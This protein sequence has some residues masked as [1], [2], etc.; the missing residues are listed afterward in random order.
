MDSVSIRPMSEGDLGAAEHAAAVTF[1][2]GDRL[3]RMADEPEPQPPT[4]DQS[5]RWVEQIGY[6]L[7]VDPQGC[8]V[9]ERDGE[10]VGFAVSQNRGPLWY[11][12]TYGVLPSEQGKG[13]GQRL[14]DAVLAHADGRPG[15]FSSTVHPAATRRYR[16]TSDPES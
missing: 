13:V 2:E 8:W 12:A 10:I 14:M 7:S 16:L 6:L 4:P 11:L 1:L 15:L 9:A 3:N 5:R